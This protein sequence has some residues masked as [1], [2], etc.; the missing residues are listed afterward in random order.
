MR[1]KA[2][3][4][5]HFC[6][7]EQEDGWV[8]CRVFK[9][10]THTRTYE[11]DL[12]SQ[13]EH[14]HLVATTVSSLMEPKQ[15]H[16]A[17]YDHQNGTI[18]DG[19]M[20]LPQLFSTESSTST[21]HHHHHHPSFLCPGPAMNNIVDME[22]SQNLLRLTSG[23]PGLVQAPERFTAD[24]SF[25]DKLLTDHQTRCNPSSQALDLGGTSVLSVPRFPFQYLGCEATDN[26]KVSK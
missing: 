6:S 2:Y 12:H 5:I 8:V 24:W 7:F 1:L 3:L 16:Q 15:N 17:I 23:G 20:Q 21:V 10:K 11:P 4:I 25:L 26:F 19:S 9:K 14:H 22:G 18:F 13:E